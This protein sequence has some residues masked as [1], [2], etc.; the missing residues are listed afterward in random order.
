MKNAPSNPLLVGEYQM[1]RSYYVNLFLLY[2][3]G[4]LMPF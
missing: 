4:I 1:K 3:N 2:P